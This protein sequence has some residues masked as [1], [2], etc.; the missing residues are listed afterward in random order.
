MILTIKRKNGTSTD[1]TYQECF[2][3]LE[4]GLSHHYLLTQN[5]REECVKA[6]E[7]IRRNFV[8]ETLNNR[9]D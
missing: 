7:R 2:D 1:C 8:K 4:K 6:L 5:E 9:K 3:A